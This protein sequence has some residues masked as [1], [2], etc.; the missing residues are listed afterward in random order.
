MSLVEPQPRIAPR[1]TSPGMSGGL[2]AQVRPPGAAKRDAVLRSVLAASGMA[3]LKLLTGIATGSLG[4]L[5]EAA[6][7]G[8]DLVASTLTLFSVRVSDKPADDD[9]TYG[10]GRVESL[11]AFVETVFMLGSSVWIV[12]E[13]VHRILHFMR[14]E[15]LSLS[16]SVWPL[17]VLLLS[18][19]VD[20]TRSRQ[21][22]RVGREE[23]SQALEA[24]ALHF[25]TDIW[26]SIAVFIGLCATFAG[27]RF[28]I[29]M[30]ELAD[31]IAAVL[32]SVIIL[33]VTWRL[34]RETVDALLDATTPEL[35]RQVLEAIGSV[36]GVLFVESLRMRRAGA[37]YFADVA[38]GMPRN[39]TFQR[40]EQLVLAATEAV[41][42]AMPGTDVVVR[43]VPVASLQESVFDR[44]RAVA[45]RA[46]LAIHD[47]SVQ[48]IDGGLTVELHLELPEHLLLRQAH[49][50]VTAIE[51]EMKREVPEIHSIVT[52]IES[53]GNTI[54]P[55]T[56]LHND[57]ALEAEVRRIAAGFAEI[58][59]VHNVVALR[60]GGHVQ[61]SC[62]CSMPDDLQMGA[63]HRIITG[64]EAAFLRD[65]PEVSRLL[66]HPEPVT[67]NDR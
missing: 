49:E 2:H 40:S 50:R 18:I 59:D 55:A 33:I 8:I 43:T 36:E 60:T 5:S 39:M 45:Q 62:H 23:H 13:A 9:H 64:L 19:S 41:Q 30:L 15:S 52:H 29:R 16:F 57:Q 17:L 14:G 6:H 56:P 58:E 28:H 46:D 12:Y 67:D 22:A 42:R 31:P 63:V 44:V 38:L 11:S 21:L 48:Q 51:A 7:S 35:R 53:E 3:L 25:G 66:I 54:E 20:Y 47:V 37:H 1:Q 10:H 65:R 24:E 27:Q 61:M 32:V 26:S 4:M 34:A